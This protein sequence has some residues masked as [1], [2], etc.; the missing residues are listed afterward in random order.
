MITR[1]NSPRLFVFPGLALTI[2]AAMLVWVYTAHAQ[3][4]YTVLYSFSGPPDDGAD[5]EAG[6]IQGPDGTLY[7]TTSSGGSG[8]VVFQVTF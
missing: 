7:G 3:A 2:A 6:L 8:G 4:I 5:P 1:P